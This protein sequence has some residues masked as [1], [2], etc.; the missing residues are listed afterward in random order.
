[1]TAVVVS[2]TQGP[3]VPRVV[4][5]EWTKLISLRSTVWIAIVTVALSWFVTYLSANAAS[6]DLGFEPH[7]SLTDG[8]GLTQLALLVLGVLAG[9]GD[10]RTGGFRATFTAVPRRLPVLVSQV[11]VVTVVAGAIAV[12]ALVAAVL[13]VLP[14]ARSRDIDLDLA[15]RKSVV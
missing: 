12:L 4:A 2:R 14:A 6:G 3:T 8:V 1:M 5:S 11:V 15:D 13:G 7:R 9:T 10:F